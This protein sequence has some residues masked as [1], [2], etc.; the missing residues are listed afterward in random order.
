[1]GRETTR[2]VGDKT[3]FKPRQKGRGQASL[4]DGGG[5]SFQHKRIVCAKI[6]NWGRARDV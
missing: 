2:S 6:L 5:K 3:I 4:E 1:M